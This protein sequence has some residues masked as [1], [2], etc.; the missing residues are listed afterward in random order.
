MSEIT[1][2]ELG[3][4]SLDFN[5]LKNALSK[6]QKGKKNGGTWMQTIQKSLLRL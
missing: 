1:E 6:A 2:N 3:F 5:D 4:K